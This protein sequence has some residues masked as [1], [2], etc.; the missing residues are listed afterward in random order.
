[1]SVFD[2]GKTKHE[3]ELE[4]AQAG[5]PKYGIYI[6]GGSAT[7]IAEAI[8][9]IAP[10]ILGIVSSESNEATKQLALKFLDST[11]PKIENCVISDVSIAL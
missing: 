1:M 11:I 10:V 7:K 6:D 2:V 5:A 8:E 4:L 9:A 3:K